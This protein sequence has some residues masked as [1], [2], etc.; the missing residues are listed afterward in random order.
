MLEK[1]SGTTT[2]TYTYGNSLVRKDGEYPMFDGLG[3]ERTV[4]NSSQT[5]TGTLTTAAFGQTVASTGSSSNPYMFAATSGYRNDGD[6]GLNH[7]GARY[8]DAQVGRFI[9]RD[10]ELDQKPYLYCGHDPVDCLDPSGHAPLWKWLLGGAGAL[11]GVA[12]MI[13]E[14]VDGLHAGHVVHHNIVKKKR[15]GPPD[16]WIGGSPTTGGVSGNPDR[17]S[18][19]GNW[20]PNDV[21]DPGGPGGR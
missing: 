19:N 9:T 12:G 4:T 16:S 15:T 14:V 7:V 6:A 17:P 2:A 10:T 1:V 13:Y 3:T 21:D 5:V 11:F 8:Y 18:K 20:N